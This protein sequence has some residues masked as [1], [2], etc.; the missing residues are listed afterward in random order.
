MTFVFALSSGLIRH[1]AVATNATPAGDAPTSTL[2]FIYLSK[3]QLCICSNQLSAASAL[4]RAPP[5]THSPSWGA[6]RWFAAVGQTCRSQSPLRPARL[7]MRLHL[8]SPPCLTLGADPPEKRRQP[9]GLARA[10]AKQKPCCRHPWAFRWSDSTER[11]G[12]A[13]RGGAVRAVRLGERLSLWS[14]FKEDF[15]RNTDIVFLSEEFHTGHKIHQDYRLLPKHLMLSL[16]FLPVQLM[17]PHTAQPG[18]F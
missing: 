15:R 16:A 9:E 13:E 6:A 10:E 7:R 5:T 2:Q 3:D 11:S 4:T 18:K 8:P 14:L 12:G 17:L 1:R